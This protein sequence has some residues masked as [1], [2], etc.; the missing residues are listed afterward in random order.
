MNHVR[1]TQ[2][3]RLF[4][5]S[6]ITALAFWM[7][8]T[9][10]VAES[11]PKAKQ[12]DQT[13]KKVDRK[14]LAYAT[15]EARDELG[16]LAKETIAGALTAMGRIHEQEKNY[17]EAT[18]TL[19]Q[20][21]EMAP[22]DPAPWAY[23]GEAYLHQK[24]QSDADAAF[25]EAEKR[26]K[27]AVAKNADDADAHYYLGLAQMYLRQ[28]SAAAASLA[29]ARQ[30]DPGNPMP[31][32]Q[33][34]VT[35]VLEGKWQDSVNLLTEALEVYPNLAYAY[36]YRGQAASKTG[37]KDMLIADLQRFLEL[38][39]DAPEAPIARRTISSVRR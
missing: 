5:L 9:A 15:Q 12:A 17:R 27:A 30:L 39:P 35:K 6:W 3:D 18:A 33:Q 29:K 26:A 36:Y 38:A 34:G 4:R 1:Y 14:L 25:R 20:A 2:F 24:R 16:G 23:L 32:Y 19:K 11:G 31:I 28:Y 10:A 22:A 7:A 37:R 8:A 21:G 13:L